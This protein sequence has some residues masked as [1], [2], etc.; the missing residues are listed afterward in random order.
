[1]QSIS[2][3]QPTPIFNEESSLPTM[4]SYEAKSAAL[5]TVHRLAYALDALNYHEL[6]PLFFSDRPFHFDIEA[7]LKTPP[8]EVTLAEYFEMATG[9]L[10]GFVAT[11]HVLSNPIVTLGGS[12]NAHIK[13]MVAAFHAL[14]VGENIEG[15]TARVTWSLDLEKHGE[16]WLIVKWKITEMVPID[17]PDLMKTGH[18]QAHDGKLRPGIVGP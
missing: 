11:Q 10:G 14:V 15:P 6:S 2:K 16:K 4:A 8:R 18:K 7:I 12:D 17:R 13:V 3:S 1:M 5:D 9:G